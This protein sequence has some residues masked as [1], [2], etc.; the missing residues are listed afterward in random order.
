MKLT[1]DSWENG[2]PI[3]AKFAFGD[4][5]TEGRF[6]LSD[7]INPHIAWSDVPTGTKSFAIIVHDPD[8]PPAARM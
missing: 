8:A 3:P 5:P 2:A 7:N 4:I 1:I 6:A